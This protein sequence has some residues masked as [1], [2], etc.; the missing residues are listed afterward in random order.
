MQAQAFLSALKHYFIAVG[1]TYI[2]TKAADTEIACQYFVVLM[3]GNI[4]RWMDRWEV[5]RNA[6]NSF[7][8]YDKL[9]IYQYT[10]LHDKNIARD[11]LHKL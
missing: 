6:P 3:A 10:L 8:E 1:I 5:Q 9:F 4:A 7:L 2:A 11:S